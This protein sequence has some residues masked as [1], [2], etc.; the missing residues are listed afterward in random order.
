MYSLSVCSPA[1]GKSDRR[2]QLRGVYRA[3]ELDCLHWQ[4]RGVVSREITLPSSLESTFYEP[5]TRLRT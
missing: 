4:Q 1:S 2:H 3:R 5:G